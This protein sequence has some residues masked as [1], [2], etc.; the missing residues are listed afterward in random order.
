MKYK[1]P[2]VQDLKAVAEASLPVRDNKSMSLLTSYA[3]LESHW[4]EPVL[5]VVMCLVVKEDAI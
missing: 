3:V 2:A 5:T 1:V 4:L